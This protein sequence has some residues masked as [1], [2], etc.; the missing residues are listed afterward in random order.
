MF[1]LKRWLIII[2][3]VITFCSDLPSIED[4]NDKEDKDEEGINTEPVIQKTME[5]T[6]VLSERDAMLK[7]NMPPPKY[8]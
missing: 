7:T 4:H 3:Y 5:T 8:K 1:F 2:T 6:A